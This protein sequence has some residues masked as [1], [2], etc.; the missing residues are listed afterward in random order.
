M[1]GSSTGTR[2]PFAIG[3]LSLGR[4]L[5]ES[6]DLV[7]HHGWPAFV[8]GILPLMPLM[9]VIGVLRVDLFRGTLVPISY[10]YFVDMLVYM[11]YKAFLDLPLAAGMLYVLATAYLGRRASIREGYRHAFACWLA[12]APIYLPL[13]M[14]IY[15]GYTLLCYGPGMLVVL[16]IYFH[17]PV[18]A[19]ERAGP[20][21]ALGRNIGLLR[22]RI[23]V[24]GLVILAEVLII[25]GLRSA[26]YAVGSP[27]VG[28]VLSLLVVAPVT[29]Y[30]AAVVVVMYISARSRH[31]SIDLQI[32]AD[33]IG[34]EAPEDDARL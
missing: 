3:D 20:F 8:V 14:V 7:K 4:V 27:Y 19:L 32:L 29:L 6:I 21:T 25:A 11:I 16:A 28:S 15:A 12:I 31:E 17:L 10:A 1:E 24:I 18:I 34:A 26:T 33:A 9:A 5:D 23:L 13:S 22:G 2:T 30:F